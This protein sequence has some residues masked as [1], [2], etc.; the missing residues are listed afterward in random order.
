MRAV[1]IGAVLGAA[2]LQHAATLPSVPA[3]AA[4]GAVLAALLCVACW[5][6][7]HGARLP[8]GIRVIAALAI[9]TC[10]A[11][12]WSAF[13][14]Q[15]RLD[16]R[17]DPAME[18]RDITVT[19]VIS[20]LPQPFERGMRFTLDVTSSEPPG[21]A[22][23]VALS[24]YN[25]WTPEEFQAVLPVRGG[26]RWR[27]VVRLK[28]PHTN[29]NP[30]GFDYEAW[31]L[32]QNIHATGSVRPKGAHQRLGEAYTTGAR[33]DRL[34]DAIRA[35]LWQALPDARYA[36]VLIALVVGDQRAIR[37]ED[38][39]TFNR[40]GV[41]HLM[42]I[43]GL[44]VTMIASLAAWLAAWGWRRSVRL[45]LWCP[46]RKAAA[47]AGVLT[48]LFYCA[49]AGFGIPAQRTLYM[50]CVAALALWLD[51]TQSASR[52]LA[53]ALIVVLVLDP[54]A[55]IAPGFWLSFAAVALIFYVG[56]RT[57]ERSYLAGWAR[58][59]WAI[60][61]GLVPLTLLLFHQVSVVSPLA[62]A[63][64]IPVISA[65]VTPLALLA[66]VL[67]IDAIAAV[68]HWLVTLLMPV[69]QWLATLPIAVWQQHA[70]SWWS[71][72]LALLGV[73]WLLAPRGIP[74]RVLAVPL[75]VPMLFAVPERPAP[76]TVWLDVLDVGQGA[77]IV[78]R[79]AHHVLVYD[80]GPAYSVEADAGARAVLPFLR[81]EGIGR[82]DRMMITHLDNDHAGGA[83]VVASTLPTGL[84]QS[85][86]PATH[87]VMEFVPYRVPCQ[88]G[89]SWQWDGVQFEVLHPPAAAYDGPARPNAMSCVLRIGAGAHAALLTGDI[90][91]R[92]EAALARADA[93]RLRADVLL[94]PHHG[95]R[96][97][98][99]VVFLDAVA[100]RHALVTAG[101]RNRFG[102]P[103]GDVVARY[104]ERGIELLR[105]DTQGALRI[106]LTPDAVATSTFRAT[107]PRY[108]R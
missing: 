44:H 77:A 34:R 17:L 90:E 72:A 97:S 81:G 99:S 82:I 42:S 69:L 87:R 46:A 91:A 66:A 104:A 20:G 79:T 70:P 5:R 108:W 7:R 53:L 105:T 1:A 26:E 51:R 30:H 96:T 47:L 22:G 14:A 68:A 49:L 54:W 83:A 19:G 40:T 15:Q 65:L 98:S 35:R 89:Q 24:W 21:V 32:E 16:A 95:S 60:T 102:H 103:R 75:F 59:Q 101:Y 41:T 107:A 8:W 48:A 36:G 10:G 94:V 85:S 25:G 74:M 23:R 71:V 55:V 12:L 43:S 31:L 18:G 37:F 92:D 67:P 106:T 56:D 39:A 78:V 100:P 63:I 11:Y 61:V 13:L 45:L 50:L 58:I 88:S 2:T 73:G 29:A 28:R 62:N 27:F 52:V 4:T 93:S 6:D 3:L 86:L 84:L 33:I 64:A 57:D 9:G 76:G 38:W 80:A